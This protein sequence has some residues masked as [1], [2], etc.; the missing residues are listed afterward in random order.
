MGHSLV[1][2]ECNLTVRLVYF[3]PKYGE[4]ATLLGPFTK[5]GPENFWRLVVNL[6]GIHPNLMCSLIK[7]ITHFPHPN[8]SKE[9]RNRDLLLLL[10]SSLLTFPAALGGFG[11][12]TSPG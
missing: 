6:G 11:G 7:K 10:T 5:L 2:R 8:P 3:F 12:S 1:S 9:N 4:F